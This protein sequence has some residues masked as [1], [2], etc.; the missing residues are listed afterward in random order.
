MT[1]FQRSKWHGQLA[2]PLENR[3]LSQIPPDLVKKRQ[4]QGAL[5]TPTQRIEGVVRAVL[6]PPLARWWS[7]KLIFFEQPR[8]QATKPVKLCSFVALLFNH[9]PFRMPQGQRVAWLAQ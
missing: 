1:F 7:F 2:K 6:C 4:F 8:N 9:S 5:E 3:R